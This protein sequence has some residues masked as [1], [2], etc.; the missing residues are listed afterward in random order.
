MSTQGTAEGPIN[1]QSSES[2]DSSSSTH[3]ANSN[4]KHEGGEP[5]PFDGQDLERSGAGELTDGD[6]DSNLIASRTVSRKL[7]CS[8]ELLEKASRSDKPIP[9][10]GKGRD[11]PPPPPAEKDDYL[12]IFDGP[13]DPMFPPNWSMKKKVVNCFVVI[14]T[15]LAVSLGSAMFSQSS[16]HVEEI[17]HVGWT[18]ATLGTSL[19]VFGFASGPIIWGPLSEL[20]GRRIVL[21]CSM[22][23][24]VCFCFA[25]ATAKD[26]QTIMICRFFSGFVGASPLVVCPAVTADLFRAASRG[27]AMAGFGAVLFGGPMLAPIFGGFTVKNPHLGW[28]WTSYFTALVGVVALILVTFLLDETHHPLILVR[29]AEEIRRRTGNRAIHAAHEEISLSF[30]EIV[31]NNI[32]RPLKMLFVEPILFLITLYNAFVY[33]LLY[34]FLTAVPLVFGVN[35]RFSQGVAELPYISM[36]IG[37]WIGGIIIILFENR[38]YKIMMRDG[39]IRPEERLPGM[40]VGSFLF[41]IGLF[42]LGWTGDYPEH[43]HWI[44]PTIGSSF[45]GAGLI[46]IF[47]PCIT[48]I[49]DV[50]LYVAASALAGNAFLRSAFGAAFPLFARQMFVNMHI[51]WASTLMG[52]VSVVLIPVP[53]L[54]YKYGAKIREKS[55]YAY[56]MGL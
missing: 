40:M 14:V 22:F 32:S 44:V 5:K 45:I 1:T 38:Y 31:E 7:T 29:R 2:N 27:K 12:V 48:Y 24:Y 9:S 23:G 36:F 51:K 17:F 46:L 42:W 10:M 4:I 35:Y 26:I 30:K 56:N 41:S 19:F 47:L 37:V 53:F 25:V 6:E 43:I 11:Y 34:L 55:K 20:F 13:D 52:C 28:R 3:T 50:Y 8:E 49:I 21:F 18:V 39:K 15:A 54:F 16:A 33:G